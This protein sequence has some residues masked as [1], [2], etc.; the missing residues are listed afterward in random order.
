METANLQDNS[1]GMA[2]ASLDARRQRFAEFVK[3][4]ALETKVIRRDEERAILRDGTTRFELPLDEARG[5][6]LVTI[7]DNDFALQSDIETQVSELVMMFSERQNGKLSKK[8]FQQAVEMYRIK[9]RS[10]FARPEIE[11][12]VKSMMEQNAIKPKRAGWILR[13]RK[14]YNKI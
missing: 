7:R 1:M 10:G 8:Q 2:R 14:W 6:M 12:R 3:I 5:V 9:A 4:Q 13:S 11:T